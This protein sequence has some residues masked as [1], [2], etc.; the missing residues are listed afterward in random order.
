M[1]DCPYYLSAA[2]SLIC[3][4]GY[5]PWVSNMEACILM[6]CAGVIVSNQNVYSGI[7]MLLPYYVNNRLSRKTRKL[8]RQ[9]VNDCSVNQPAGKTSLFIMKAAPSMFDVS[10]R[11][12]TSEQINKNV[13]EMENKAINIRKNFQ[14]DCL[15][16]RFNTDNNAIEPVDSSLEAYLQRFINYN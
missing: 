8:I 11:P 1:S 7:M 4:A 14:H 12:W 9:L 13:W 10:T 16:R 5:W 3:R 15:F 2:A 6:E